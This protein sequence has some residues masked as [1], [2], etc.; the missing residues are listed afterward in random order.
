MKLDFTSKLHKYEDSQLKANKDLQDSQ[1]AQ[2]P[3]TF[4]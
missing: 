4:R 3:D 1:K 2:A